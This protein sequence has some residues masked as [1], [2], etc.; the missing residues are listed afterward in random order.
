[1]NSSDEHEDDDDEDVIDDDTRDVLICQSSYDIRPAPQ[2][3][4]HHHRAEHIVSSFEIGSRRSSNSLLAYIHGARIFPNLFGGRRS[5][6]RRSRQIKKVIAA[7]TVVIIL[8][9]SVSIAMRKRSLPKHSTEAEDYGDECNEP[10]PPPLPHSIQLFYPPRNDEEIQQLNKRLQEYSDPILTWEDFVNDNQNGTTKEEDDSN[11]P[12][13][14]YTSE[15]HFSSSRTALMFAP[16]VYPNL[17]F[18]VGY[19]TSVLGLGARPIDVVFT[20]CEYGPHVP[21]LDKF[22]NRP[23]NGSGLNTFW[24]SI[25]N[26]ATE[27]RRGMVWAVSQAAPLRRIHVRADLN[28]FDADSWVSGGVAANIIVDGMVNF[29][30]QQQWLMR[31]VELKRGAVNGAW[32]LVFAGCTGSVPNENGG[33][34]GP[35]PSI[36]VEYP[37]LRVEKPYITMKTD[38]RSLMQSNGQQNSMNYVLELRVPSVT[39]GKEATGP[40]FDDSQDI[41]DFR[42][43]KL[44]VPSILGQLENAATENHAILQKALDDGKDLV[45]SPGIYPLSDT[46]TVR[47]KNQVIL[48]LGYATLVAPHHDG[49]PCIRVDSRVP[50]VRIAGIMLEASVLR[51]NREGKGASLLEWGTPNS[52]DPGDDRNPGVLTDVFVRI[53]GVYRDVSADVMIQLHSGNI[54]G[55]NLWLWRADHVKLHWN[56]QPNFPHISTKFRQTVAGE[57]EVKNGLVVNDGATN[58]T[59]VGLAVEHT[60]EDQVIWNADNGKQLLK[61]ISLESI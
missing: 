52:N 61:L 48:G 5:T 32:S 50:G 51:G 36:S 21:A 41:R 17:D 22:T 53:G 2:H 60:T 58:I 54:Y 33:M 39:H 56:E 7:C 55:D 25:E 45:L 47:Y 14:T 31:N 1:M 35:G 6:T 13:F 40:H 9:A 27:A 46:L 15:N 8:V 44:A 57:C 10:N 23:P 34:R 3:H 38:D 43:V 42:R 18:E 16:G 26:I 29:G 19:Y 49:S 59:I 30:G 20:N 12:A 28:L 24:R 37:N 4:H 11:H